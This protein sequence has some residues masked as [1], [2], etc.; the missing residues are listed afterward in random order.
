MNELRSSGCD[1]DLTD[2]EVFSLLANQ[3]RRLTA[4][5]LMEVES[6]DLG[7]LAERIGGIEENVDP[8]EVDSSTRKSVYTSLQQVH[9]P[10]LDDADIIEFDKRSGTICQTEN[11]K[12]FIEHAGTLQNDTEIPWYE[13]Y[14]SLSS[15]GFALVYT[16]TVDADPFTTLPDI[17][18]ECIFLFM[19]LTVSCLHTLSSLKRWDASAYAID[20]ITDMR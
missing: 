11:T 6:V 12:L 16:M 20:K 17:V 8:A 1:L 3:R 10:K 5:I 4:T 18:Y 19:L 7:V 13:Y 2:D 9:L 15:L 14:L